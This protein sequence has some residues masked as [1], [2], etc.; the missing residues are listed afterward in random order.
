MINNSYVKQFKTYLQL[1]RALSPNS[2]EA[3]LNDVEKLNQYYEVMNRNLKITD[4]SFEDL[5]KFVTWLNELGMLPA[6]QGRV[7]SGLKA[8]FNFLLIEKLI[9][10]SPAELLEAPKLSRTLP[11]VLHIHEVNALIEA[12]DVSKPEGMRNKVI[13]EVLYGCGLRVSE[14]TDLLIS[15]INY[16]AEFIM[17]VGKGNKERI[18][19]IGGIALKLIR[20]YISEVRVHLK[21]KKGDEDIVFL[22]RYGAQL[23]RISVFKIVKALAESIGLQKSIS[24]HTLRHS[25]ATHLIE[26]GADLRAVQEMLG[27]SSITT[28]EIYTHLDRA[29]LQGVITQFHPRS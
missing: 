9:E 16:D 24:P 10:T 22:N 12:I 25:F 28:T 23:S 15:N 5:T 4:I 14:L 18:V 2:V 1:E 8:Y 7:I 27:H 11:D 26:G 29:Y 19:P 20:L 6:T 3:Y 21:I 13:I 17:V